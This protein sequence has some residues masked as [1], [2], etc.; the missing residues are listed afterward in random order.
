MSP[1]LIFSTPSRTLRLLATSRSR[2]TATASCKGSTST[3]TS[4]FASSRV[5]H[6]VSP[7]EFLNLSTTPPDKDMPSFDLFT[8]SRGEKVTFVGSYSYP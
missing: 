1:E 8:P 6:E 3:G 4:S 5:G 2:T 7:R